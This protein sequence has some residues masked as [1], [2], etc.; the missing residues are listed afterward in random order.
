MSLLID[1]SAQVHVYCHME[2]LRGLLQLPK[3][4]V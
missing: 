1:V 3:H 2:L 4:L